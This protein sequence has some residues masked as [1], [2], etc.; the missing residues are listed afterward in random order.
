MKK[1][2]FCLIIILFLV[3]CNDNSSDNSNSEIAN[4]A[5]QKCV[6][7]GYTLDIRENENGDQTGYCILSDEVECEEWD[8]FRG[9]CV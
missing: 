7:D 6:D 2:I 4:P 5:S 8:Y 9:N 3:S 1:I